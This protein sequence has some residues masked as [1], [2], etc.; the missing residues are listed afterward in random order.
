MRNIIKNKGLIIK[1]QDYLENA[2]LATILTEK[3]KESLIIRGAKK[4]N[5]STRRLGNILTLIEF[6]HTESKGLS[7]LTEGIVINNYT[8]IKDDLIRYNYALVILEKISF[9]ME[10][11]TDFPTLYNFTL[12]LLNKL[13]DTKYLNAI[14][15][16]FEIKLLYLLGVAPSFNR[17]P[18]CGKKAINAA[19]DIKSGGFICEDCHYLKETSLDINDSLLFKKIYVTKLNEIDENFLIQ[20]NNHQNIN[21]CINSY[22]EW[23]LD[24]KSKVLDIIEKIG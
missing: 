21:K 18:I 22:Y 9:F 8:S 19:L 2:V 24:F 15:L 16:I 10:Q 12:E 23:H 4:M 20:I 6:N 13:N 3:G 14:I 1:T 11:I 7:T 5:T 17:C